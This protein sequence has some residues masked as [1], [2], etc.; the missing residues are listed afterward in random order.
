[1]VFLWILRLIAVL[2]AVYG[3]VCFYRADIFSYMFLKVE[4]AFLDYRK[5]CGFNL[6]RIYGNDGIMGIYCLLCVKSVGEIINLEI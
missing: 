6:R 5:E 1:M 3:A 4:F 2:I